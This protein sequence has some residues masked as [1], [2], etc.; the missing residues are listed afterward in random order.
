MRLSSTL[1][2]VGMRQNVDISDHNTEKHIFIAKT[3]LLPETFIVEF[4][5]QLLEIYVKLHIVEEILAH[6][7][8]KANHELVLLILKHL[9]S[10]VHFFKGEEEQLLEE[11]LTTVHQLDR[12]GDA[13]VSQRKELSQKFCVFQENMGLL[14]FSVDPCSE[15]TAALDEFID[16]ETVLG[17]EGDVQQFLQ[18]SV[19]ESSQQ[20][21]IVAGFHEVSRNEVEQPHHLQKMDPVLLLL[22]FLLTHHLHMLNFAQINLLRLHLLDLV[23]VLLHQ[24]LSPAQ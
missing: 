17:V 1:C 20:L 8:D 19:P 11:S 14:L 2:T 9:E 12:R 23:H 10:S 22:D 15:D 4:H 3:Y 5:C 6:L 7:V 18:K 21:M 16:S 13:R 24:H